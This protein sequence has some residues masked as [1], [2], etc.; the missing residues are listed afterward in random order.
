M[1]FLSLPTSELL[2][3]GTVGFVVYVLVGVDG[4]CELLRPFLHLPTLKTIFGLPGPHNSRG[5]RFGRLVP[6]GEC[7]SVGARARME[8]QVLEKRG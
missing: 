2:A 3:D 7:L 6:G 1:C 5:Q 4:G 8:S